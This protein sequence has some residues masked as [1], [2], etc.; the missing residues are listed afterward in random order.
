MTPR[1][2]RKV[3]EAVMRDAGMSK[4]ERRS[5]RRRMRTHNVSTNNGTRRVKHVQSH[6]GYDVLWSLACLFFG[7]KAQPDFDPDT[8]LVVAEGGE[9]DGSADGVA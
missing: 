9:N 4:Q 8:G 1:T 2:G 3:Q 7:L 5:V 6:D